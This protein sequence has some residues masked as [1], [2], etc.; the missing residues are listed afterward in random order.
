MQRFSQI[1]RPGFVGVG[2]LEVGLSSL[3]KL[4][5]ADAHAANISNGHLRLIGLDG[6]LVPGDLSN[7]SMRAAP[8]L[9]PCADHQTIT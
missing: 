3:P 9:Q 4:T 1:Y 8:V 5:D 6:G 2:D 7:K